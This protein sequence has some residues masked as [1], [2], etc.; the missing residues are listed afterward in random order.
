M[1]VRRPFSLDLVYPIP[2]LTPFIGKKSNLKDK[3]PRIPVRLVSKVDKE[4]KFIS[5]AENEK[6]GTVTDTEQ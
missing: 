2:E 3:Q 4:E 1:N 5:G 6:S